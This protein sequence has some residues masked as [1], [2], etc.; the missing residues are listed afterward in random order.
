VE[1]DGVCW[2]ALR[3]LDCLIIIK[4]K[5]ETVAV[6]LIVA[7][8]TGDSHAHAISNDVISGLYA[9]VFIAPP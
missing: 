2:V 4:M 5:N 1:R 6:M 3:V 9:D 8:R 7:Y